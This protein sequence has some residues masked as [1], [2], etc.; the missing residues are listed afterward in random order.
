MYYYNINI[1][2]QLLMLSSCAL[3]GARVQYL[4]MQDVYGGTGV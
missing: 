4:C 1:M 2:L 3:P